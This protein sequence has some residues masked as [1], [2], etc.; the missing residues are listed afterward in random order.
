MVVNPLVTLESVRLV[1]FVRVV[2]IP[3]PLPDVVISQVVVRKVVVVTLFVVEVV[4]VVRRWNRWKSSQLKYKIKR[5]ELNGL[6]CKQ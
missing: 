1:A 3:L 6:Y 5:D 4:V 2:S